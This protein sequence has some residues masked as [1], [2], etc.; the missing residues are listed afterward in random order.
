MPLSILPNNPPSN[1]NDNVNVV[2]APEDDFEND[3]ASK[4]VLN[5]ELLPEKP[6]GWNE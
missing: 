3:D 4:S 1:F 2:E 6:N 5:E